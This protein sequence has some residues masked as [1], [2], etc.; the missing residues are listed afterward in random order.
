MVVLAL[1]LLEIGHEGLPSGDHVRLFE[2]DFDHF[3]EICTLEDSQVVFFVAFY[4]DEGMGANFEL[5]YKFD[6]P[7][8][9][10]EGGLGGG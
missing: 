8:E 3:G 7:V 4:E 5:A 1:L 10:F 2:G 9:F 6:I